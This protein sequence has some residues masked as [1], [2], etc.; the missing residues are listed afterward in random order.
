MFPPS[1]WC[2]TKKLSILW[3][4]RYH[5]W[6]TNAASF[7]NSEMELTLCGEE[8]GPSIDPFFRSMKLSVLEMVVVSQPLMF[9]ICYIVYI[10]P[11]QWQW[12][13]GHCFNLKTVE[14]FYSKLQWT[15]DTQLRKLRSRAWQTA[16][17]MK[18]MGTML[19]HS[20]THGLCHYF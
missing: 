1:L 16:L 19:K 10:Q 11:I 8:V 17:W 2:L 7:P 20:Q 3:E 15:I 14:F 9:P 4:V 13:R 18:K 6:E 5:F 12:S